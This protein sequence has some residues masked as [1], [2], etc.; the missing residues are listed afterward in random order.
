[1]FLVSHKDLLVNLLYR[2]VTMMWVADGLRGSLGFS[3]TTT[4]PIKTD[5]LR[6]SIA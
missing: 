1:M 6:T 2:Q 4:I 3:G 5:T